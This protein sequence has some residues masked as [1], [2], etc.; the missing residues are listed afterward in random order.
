MIVW[1][2]CAQVLLLAAGMLSIT[3]VAEENET[4]KLETPVSQAGTISFVLQTDKAYFNGQ[5]QDDYSQTLVA[6]PGISEILFRR[7]DSVVNILWVW[8]DR[9]GFPTFYDTVV[10]F[11]DLPGPESY[12]LLFTWDSAKG[13]SEAYINGI[14]LRLPRSKFA[15]WWVKQSVNRIQTGSGHLNVVDLKVRDTYTNPEGT[16]AAVPV[17]LRGKYKELIGNPMPPQPVV[18]MAQRR[19]ELLYESSMADAE[20]VKAWKAEG[21]LHLRFEDGAMLMRSK[22]FE[23]HTVFWCPVDFPESFVA[24]WDFQAL[25]HYG[26]AIAFF[27][28]RGEKGED[29]FDPSLPPRD[30]N[31][32]HYIKGAITSYHISYFANIENFQMGRTDSNLRKNNKFYRVGGGPVAVQPDALGWQRIRLVKDGNHIQ[33]YN[34][35]VLYVDWTDDDPER[36]GPPHGGGKIGLRQMKPTIGFY[37]N[38]RV[39]SLSRSKR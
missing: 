15:P 8:Q 4:L 19:G 1:G 20:S 10:D 13:I 6:L 32:G 14:P 2:K 17:G 12:F 3:A 27:A 39:Y 16:R 9:A 5:G 36:Y 23:Q 35:G 25:S 30:G 22:N 37:R 7:T 28:A 31:F 33:L 38:F 26:L 21:P 18:D 11:Y 34:N 29:V 24:E